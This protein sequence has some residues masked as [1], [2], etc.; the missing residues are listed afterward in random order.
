MDGVGFIGLGQMGAAMAA[1]LVNHRGG[2]HLFDIRLNAADELVQSGAHR[3]ESIADLA[4]RCEL[5]ELMVVD[6][7]QVRDVCCGPDGVIAHARDRAIIAVH[8]TIH[9][10]TAVQLGHVVANQRPDMSVIDAPVSGG[11]IAALDANLAVMVGGDAEAVERARSTMECWA[12]LVIHLGPLGA[13]TRAKLA[14]NL[15]HF[16]SFTA[17]NEAQQLAEAYGIDLRSLARVIRH[18]DRITGG[19]SSIMLRDHTRPLE[20][21]DEWY[22]TLTRVRSLGEKDLALALDLADEVNLDLPLAS[23]AFEQFAQ[24]LGLQPGSHSTRR[25]P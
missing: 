10:D 17:A 16:I 20:P 22:D 2:L 21:D 19:A 23:V 11:F 7:D 5:V 8:S 25:R 1:H 9:P 6:D 18:T 15:L 12:S 3:C 14:R 13:G 4:Q 24:S